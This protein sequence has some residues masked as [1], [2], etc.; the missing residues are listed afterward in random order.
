MDLIGMIYANNTDVSLKKQCMAGIMYQVFQYYR[1]PLQ[2]QLYKC[3]KE[4]FLKLSKTFM[5]RIIRT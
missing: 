1:S 4:L 5:R 3:S 2:L